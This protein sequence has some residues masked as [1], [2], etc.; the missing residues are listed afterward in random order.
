MQ[1]EATPATRATQAPDERRAGLAEEFL[2]LYGRPP[3]LWARAPG[4]VDLM[5]SHTDYNLGY[6]MT[7][8]VD[9]DVWIAAA[10]RADG[11]VCVAS[12]NVPGRSEFALDE[13][14]ILRDPHT[15]WANYVRAVAAELLA[16]GAPLAGC[17]ALIHS[18]VPT[19][20]GLSSSAA[21]ELAT[22]W[23]FQLAGGFSIA[24]VALALLC[25]R[26]EN[27]FVGVNCG[28]L[29]QYSSALGQAG[30]ALLLDCRDLSTSLTPLAENVAVVICDTRAERN[31][32]GTEYDERRAQ[33]E[34]GVACLREVYPEAQSLRDISLAQFTAEEKRLP[35]VIARRCRFILEENA[36]VLALAEALPGGSAGVLGPLF[37][38]SY[39]GA[40]DLYEIGAPAFTAMAEAAAQ[41]P[42]AIAVRQAGAGFGGCMVALVDP[43]AI[44]PFTAGVSA[45]YYSRT[46]INPHLF[47]VAPSAGAGPLPD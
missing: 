18:T 39:A 26:A 15:P 13:G 9:R 47:A 37:A 42:G 1:A 44:A 33:C 43:A 36:R 6:V 38:A 32:A 2:R 21:L 7:M 19:G 22:A 4:R 12:R 35:P 25:Q 31:L 17:D 20:S 30:A 10:P 5:G 16:A 41:A 46:G 8:T 29:D 34:L 24:P 27:R 23:T 40:R 3:T 11:R 45:T 14:P 28:I